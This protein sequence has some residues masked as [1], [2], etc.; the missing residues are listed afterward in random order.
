MLSQMIPASS[1]G[2]SQLGTGSAVDQGANGLW[3]WCVARSEKK[4]KRSPE[5]LGMGAVTRH[6]SRR[7]YSL[8]VQARLNSWMSQHLFFTRKSM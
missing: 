5:V 8:M 7:E 2:S 4:K 6:H 3:L 1:L